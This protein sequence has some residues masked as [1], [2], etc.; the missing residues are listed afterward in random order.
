MK[1][2]FSRRVHAL[3]PIATAC[4]AGILFLASITPI[5]GGPISISVMPV[6]DIGNAADGSLYGAVGYKYN[7]GTYDVTLT[8]Y[9]AFLNAVAATDPN[10]LYNPNMATDPNV[11][12]ISRIGSSGSYTYALIGSGQRPVTYVSFYDAFRFCNWL[13]NGQGSGGTETGVYTLLGSTSVAATPTDHSALVGAGTTK[14]FIP[15]RNEWYKAA[16]YKGGNSNA[17]YWGYPFK[18][19]S[20]PLPS[21]PPGGS[22]SANYGAALTGGNFNLNQNYLSDVGAYTTSSSPYGLFDMGG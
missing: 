16:Y 4:F 2:N 20:A 10:N 3:F 1:T 11:A 21:P 17:G 6:G 18:S 13:T 5:Y 14:Y 22:N 12:G 8:Q 7:I 15:T 9:T 19:D